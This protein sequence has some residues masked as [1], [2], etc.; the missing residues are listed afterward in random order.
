[1]Q[2]EGLVLTGMT[3]GTS[4]QGRDNAGASGENASSGGKSVLR[5]VATVDAVSTV[6]ASRTPQGALDLFV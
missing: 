1:M 3:V 5:A 2:R 6:S 4:A